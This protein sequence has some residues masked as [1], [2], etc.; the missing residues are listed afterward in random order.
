MSEKKTSLIMKP[1]KIYLKELITLEELHELML[2]NEAAF[3]GKFKLKKGLLGKSIVFD[4]YMNI[5]PV[6]HVKDNMVKLSVVQQSTSVGVGGMPGIDIKATK[7]RMEAAKAGG[8]TKAITGGSE[9]YHGVVEA[10]RGLLGSR[11]QQ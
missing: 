3:P 5:K 9:Y 11:V 1:E 6:I 8:F 7:Q 4:L 10:T 2:Q